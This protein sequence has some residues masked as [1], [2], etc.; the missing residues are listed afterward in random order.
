MK[1][2]SRGAAPGAAR[3]AAREKVELLSH[4]EALKAE[5]K[6]CSEFPA[7]TPSSGGTLADRV[8]GVV[9]RDEG[10]VHERALGHIDGGGRG[11][12]VESEA[13]TGSDENSRIL[14][15]CSRARRIVGF[16][17]I[18]PRMIE[19]QKEAYGAKDTEEAM[20]MEI[21]SYL[22]CEMKVKPTDIER[23]DFVRI[24]PPA[25]TDWDTLYV[26]FGTETEVDRLFTHTRVIQKSDHRLVR[27]IPKELYERFRALDSISYTMRE[28][29]KAQGVKLR[30]RIKVGRLDL[31]FSLKS[32]NSVW[33]SEPLP[34][35]LP[36]IDLEATRRSSLSSSPPPGR[37]NRSS[38]TSSNQVRKR[39]F[40]GSDEEETVKKVREAPNKDKM[41]DMQGVNRVL[42]VM[43]GKQSLQEVKTAKQGTKEKHISPTLDAPELDP[44][45]FTNQE[46][47]CPST[48]AKEKI[49]PDIT[50]PIFRNKA[51]CSK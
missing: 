38:T 42:Q 29:M 1:F 36:Q 4:F 23:I 32:P 22:K 6:T 15:I 46:G 20:L 16:T 31:E 25:K 18:E 45:Q 28:N 9:H 7:L 44:G 13:V 17:P 11:V 41:V 50:S 33:R 27:W 49:I 30:T 3:G 47:Y 26:E 40:S 21:K 39:P 2:A 8:N 24:F 35:G 14:D 37:P 12:R 19:I 5:V 34:D 43:L 10:G 48:P 51:N